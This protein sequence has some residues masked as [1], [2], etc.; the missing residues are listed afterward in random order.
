MYYP[1]SRLVNLNEG[2]STFAN[3]LDLLY[4]YESEFEG[5]AGGLEVN[6]IE[7]RKDVG[8]R[9]GRRIRPIVEEG[10]FL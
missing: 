5:Y 4:H 7:A 2:G 10:V 3:Y 8:D 9:R 1:E 6:I